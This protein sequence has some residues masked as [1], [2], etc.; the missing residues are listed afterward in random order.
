MDYTVIG[1]T[2]NIASRLQ[3][4][5]VKG[6]IIV[7]QVTYETVKDHVEAVERLQQYV[8]GRDDPIIYY[9]LKKLVGAEEFA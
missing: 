4:V 3:E 5:A 6:Q 9:D 8:E 2:A 7:G 1:D